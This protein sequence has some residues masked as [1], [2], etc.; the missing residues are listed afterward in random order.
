MTKISVKGQYQLELGFKTGGEFHPFAESELVS[1][2]IHQMAGGRPPAFSL[3]FVTSDDTVAGKV[4]EGNPIT[5]KEGID[6]NNTSTST[7]LPLKPTIQKQAEHKLR[8]TCEGTLNVPDYLHTARVKLYG[9]AGGIK[10]ARQ[11]L[12]AHFDIHPDSVA[13]SDDLMNYAQPNITDQMFVRDLTRHAWIRQGAGW[14]IPA[15]TAE[16]LKGGSKPVFRLFDMDQQIQTHK[17]DPIWRFTNDEPGYLAARAKAT[18]NK[19]QAPTNA[20]AKAG[21]RG[22]PINFNEDWIVVGDTG[23]MNQI[24]GYDRSN[25]D[26]NMESTGVDTQQPILGKN[27]LTQNPN[28]IRTAGNAQ[29]VISA[30]R[31]GYFGHNTHRQFMLAKHTNMANRAL[32]S[33]FMLNVSFRDAF[34]PINLLDIVSIVIG[35]VSDRT[36]PNVHLSGAYIVS[37]VNRSYEN[38]TLMTT[39]TL[40]REGPESAQG[41]F[42]GTATTQPTAPTPAIPKPATTTA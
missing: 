1:L 34:Y 33:S 5:I 8:I 37:A 27:R 20:A 32:F 17:P 23:L 39:V 2:N 6:D 22:I 21:K 4:N 29:G 41:S 15:I 7:F 24:Y 10:V 3:T 9:A 19:T 12:A 25:L 11:V 18:K 30:G 35:S 42:Q 28:F 36:K 26:Y 14:N 38:K 13:D 31:H 16:S 40:V